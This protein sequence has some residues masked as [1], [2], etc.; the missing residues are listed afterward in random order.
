MAIDEYANARNALTLVVEIG[1]NMHVRRRLILSKIRKPMP[2]SIE[3][4][5][6]LPLEGRRRIEALA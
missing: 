3:V 1:L 2:V 4:L 6:E 5:E